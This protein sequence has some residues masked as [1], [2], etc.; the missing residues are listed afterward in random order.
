MWSAV[1]EVLTNIYNDG[2]FKKQRAQVL[3]LSDKMGSYEFVFIAHLMKEILGLTA[4]L[5]FF[6]QQKDQNIVAAVG[7]IDMTKRQFQQ[8]SDH[9]WENLV[10]DVNSFCDKH[11]ISIIK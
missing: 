1:L 5:S 3:G 11:D 8:L 4:E 6:L 2:V 9:G 7:L 10:E